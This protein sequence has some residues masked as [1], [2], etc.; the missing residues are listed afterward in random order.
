MTV[1]VLELTLIVPLLTGAAVNVALLL[2]LKLPLL[3]RLL[4]MAPWKKNAP[5]FVTGPL[6]NVFAVT[7]TVAELLTP[8]LTVAPATA[9]VR[10]PVPPSTIIRPFEMVWPLRLNVPPLII[11]VLVMVAVLLSVTVPLPEFTKLLLMAPW[12]KNAPRLVTGPLK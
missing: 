2:R 1:K 11:V 10:T 3:T 12:K 4:L 5:K 7:A 8:P 9:F 6:K